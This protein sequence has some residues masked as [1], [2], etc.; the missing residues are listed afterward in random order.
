[1]RRGRPLGLWDVRGLWV[2]E[3]E[4][5]D[6]EMEEVQD[7]REVGLTRLTGGRL[8]LLSERK[9]GRLGAGMVTVLSVPVSVSKNGL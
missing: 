2:D 9:F 6:S 1:M 5:E 7:M 3:K 8:I 4:Y